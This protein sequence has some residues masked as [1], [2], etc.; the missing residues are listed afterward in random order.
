MSIVLPTHLL[1]ISLCY[2]S[3]LFCYFLT[4]LVYLV[5]RYSIRCF[6]RKNALFTARYLWQITIVIAGL[7]VFDH[8]SD[9]NNI[10]THT[11]VMVKCCRMC[12]CN[13]L[14]IVLTDGVVLRGNANM[15]ELSNLVLKCGLRKSWA[16]KKC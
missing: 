1:C 12:V 16:T 10:H 8:H 2:Y 14:G 5:V 11:S 15:A 6:Q 7:W 9:N 4:Q 3:P 13:C